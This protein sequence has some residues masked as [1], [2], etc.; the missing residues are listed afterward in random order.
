MRTARISSQQRDEREKGSSTGGLRRFTSHMQFHSEVGVPSCPLTQRPIS[1][2][3]LIGGRVGL[4]PA[5]SSTTRGDSKRWWLHNAA[6]VHGQLFSRCNMGSTGRHTVDYGGGQQARGRSIR[7]GRLS[8][9]NDKGTD[10]PSSCVREEKS[11]LSERD[12]D[13]NCNPK[14]QTNRSP[15]FSIPLRS[16]K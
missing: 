11:N 6:A 12:H 15:P 5:A 4:H 9:A 7:P 10:V 13:P 2:L 3:W 14:P 8:E 1:A 16:G